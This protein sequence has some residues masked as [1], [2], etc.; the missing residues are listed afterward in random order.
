[1]RANKFGIHG[2]VPAERI[3]L[4]EG[5]DVG[6]ED[7]P[8]KDEEVG[9]EDVASKEKE[10]G[11][12]DV[13]V[14]EK[15]GVQNVAS[16]EEEVGVVDVASEEEEVGVD[17]VVT[18]EG[19]VD[20]PRRAGME[21]VVADR[22]GVE[23]VAAKEEAEDVVVAEKAGVEDMASKQEKV[24]VVAL[25]NKGVKIGTACEEEGAS[26]DEEHVDYPYRRGHLWPRKRRAE[27]VRRRRLRVAAATGG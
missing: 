5:E 20:M 1:M 6:V 23:N 19:Q 25:A 17:D 18:K 9:V 3:L 10:V 14:T 2:D 26:E 4:L 13:V 12:E 16:R 22:V 15:V 24:D 8:S 27:D 7:E 11:V 21:A